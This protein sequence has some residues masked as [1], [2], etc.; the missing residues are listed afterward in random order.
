MDETLEYIDDYFKGEFSPTQAVQF[1]RRILEDPAFAGEVA[2][3][4]SAAE[5]ARDQLSEDKKTR[6]REIYRLSG[7][8]PARQA[9]R[10]MPPVR[11]LWAAL[12]VAAVI[13]AIVAGWWLFLKPATPQQLA[14]RFARENWKSL[15]LT[16]GATVDSMQAALRLYNDGQVREAGIAFEKM[17]GSD[18]SNIFAKTYAGIVSFRLKDYDKAL[19]WFGLLEKKH[20]EYYVNPAKFYQAITLM[21]RDHPGDKEQARL[22]L[23]QV[24]EKDLDGKEFAQKW[25]KDF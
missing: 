6:F 23:Q 21:E 19:F 2:F 10:R 18:S 12:S 15:D 14:D 4:L 17:V 1:E 22:L 25:I 13:L 8:G 24:I 9:D 16:M 5:A 7:Q 3:Y 11:K 20:K